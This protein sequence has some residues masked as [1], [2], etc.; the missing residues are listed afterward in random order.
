MMKSDDGAT[1]EAYL[2]WLK[3]QHKKGLVCKK[4]EQALKPGEKCVLCQMESLIDF[5]K[6]KWWERLTVS[7]RGYL[8]LNLG[9]WEEW[10]RKL[11]LPLPKTI[12]SRQ[13]KVRRGASP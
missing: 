7:N 11:G 10:R 5:S 3:K 2:D 13:Q 8:R 9:P 6:W 1:Y 12:Q 4:H